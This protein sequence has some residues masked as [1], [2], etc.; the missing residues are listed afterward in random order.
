MKYFTK[1]LWAQINDPDKAV[2]VE[3]DKVWSENNIRYQ[4]EWEVVK[5]YLSNSFVEQFTSNYGFH[6]YFIHGIY[7]I[8]NPPKATYSCMLRLATGTEKCK[9]VMRG[10]KSVNMGLVSLT[11]LFRGTLEWGYSEFDI[12]ERNTITLSVLCAMKS[13]MQFEFE[14]IE[15]VPDLDDEIAQVDY[16]RS[17]IFA[18]I[19]KFFAVK[20]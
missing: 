5:K 14:T 1:E 10:L 15:I 12:T 6:D 9:I 16:N 2:R 3:A 20:R 8:D 18:R 11:D 19:K 7:V 4:Q 17:P 13:E